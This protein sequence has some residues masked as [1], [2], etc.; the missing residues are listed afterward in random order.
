M[1]GL[2]FTV[3]Y[4]I[5]TAGLAASWYFSSLWSFG[6]FF[7]LYFVVLLVDYSDPD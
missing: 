7:A 5:L 3:I 4:L 1:R 6:F 2:I